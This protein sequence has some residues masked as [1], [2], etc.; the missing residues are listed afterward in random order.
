LVA[1]RDA[2]LPI[3]TKPPIVQQGREERLAKRA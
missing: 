3:L 1:I 2:R